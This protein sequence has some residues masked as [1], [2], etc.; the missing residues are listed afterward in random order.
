[1]RDA[2][3]PTR[4]IRSSRRRSSSSAQPT[5]AGRLARWTERARIFRGASRRA[6]AAPSIDLGLQPGRARLDDRR[7]AARRRARLPAL[8][9]CCCRPRCCSSPGS[10]CTRTPS[11]RARAEV[12]KEAGLHGLIASQVAAAASSSAR[13]LVFV[14]MVPAVLYAL[15]KLYRAIAIVHAIVWDGTGRGVRITPQGRRLAR[16]GDPARTSSPPRSSAGSAGTTSS[17]G[18]ARCS[19]TSPSSAARGSSSRCSCRTGT[20][21]GPRSSRAPLLVG[22]GLLFVNVF[23]VY[24]TTRLVEVAPTRTARSASPPRCCLSLVLVGRLIVVSA[25]LNATLYERRNRSPGGT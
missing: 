15:V 16:R 1:M 20:F 9:R 6:R 7:R 25:E 13:W 21:A 3:D 19:S 18:S 24:V 4:P 14:V 17:A 8:R 10:G 12:A 22:V 2:A 5:V 11:T 23:N